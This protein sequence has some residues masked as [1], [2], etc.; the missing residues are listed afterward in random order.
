[1]T[2][3]LSDKLKPYS[4]KTADDFEQYKKVDLKRVLCKYGVLFQT[5][6]T[7]EVRRKF[8][9]D[10]REDFDI[11]AEESARFH[12][13]QE[14]EPVI[15]AEVAADY[16]IVLPPEDDPSFEEQSRRKAN[17]TRMMSRLFH[18]N[19][20][21]RFGSL[22]STNLPK[23]D[24]HKFLIE[25]RKICSRTLEILRYAF[26]TYIDEVSSWE[27]DYDPHKLFKYVDERLQGQ[28][29]TSTI[30]KVLIRLINMKAINNETTCKD[31]EK[32]INECLQLC[33]ALLKDN[34][35]TPE[36]IFWEVFRGQILRIYANADNNYNILRTELQRSHRESTV[37]TLTSVVELVNKTNVEAAHNKG[38]VSRWSGDDS[39]A[40]ARANKVGQKRPNDKPSPNNN[41]QARIGY[42]DRVAPTG[43]VAPTN[44][45]APDWT[46]KSTCDHTRHKKWQ[47]H[48][49][50]E[51]FHYQ[52]E[53]ENKRKKAKGVR[54]DED[55]LS[56][57]CGEVAR[58]SKSQAMSGNLNIDPTSGKLVLQPSDH[59]APVIELPRLPADLEASL[60]RLV[61]NRV[62]DAEKSNIFKANWDTG[63]SITASKLLPLFSNLK[64]GNGRTITMADDSIAQ[65]NGVGDLHLD[66]GPFKRTLGGSYFI[67]QWGDTLISVS[68]LLG[69]TKSR[70]IFTADGTYFDDCE[71]KLRYHVGS[72]I[73][74]VYYPLKYSPVVGAVTDLE[75][76]G[77]FGAPAKVAKRTTCVDTASD[78]N[79]VNMEDV[80]SLTRPQKK[81][82]IDSSPNSTATDPRTLTVHRR[83]GHLSHQVVRDTICHG[84]VVCGDRVVKR[85]ISA[86]KSGMSLDNHGLCLTCDVVKIRKKKIGSSTTVPRRILQIVHTDKV[87][88]T[89]IGRN[90]ETHWSPVVDGFSRFKGIVYTKKSNS[91]SEEVYNYIRQL[92][93]EKE[94]NVIELR[95]DGGSEFSNDFKD[96]LRNRESPIKFTN[97]PPYQK[98]MNGTAEA[99]VRTI[100]NV[101]ECLHLQ[102]TL[103]DRFYPDCLNTATDILNVTL[104]SSI[105]KTPYEAFHGKKPNIDRLRAFGCL[106]V[107]YQTED[108][109]YR[110]T[111]SYK[112]NHGS[113]GIFLGYK[114]ESI[115]KI[116]DL[117]RQ[118]M[119]EKVHVKFHEDRFPGLRYSVEELIKSVDLIPGSRSP[120]S[121]D[122]IREIWNNTDAE[123]SR[124]QEVPR[125][126]NRAE[127]NLP[128]DSPAPEAR[129]NLRQRTRQDVGSGPTAPA[130]IDPVG[131]GD[132]TPMAVD[133]DSTTHSAADA[134]PPAV[135]SAPAP[136]VHDKVDDEATFYVELTDES[137][138][139][140]LGTAESQGGNV[141]NKGPVEREQHESEIQLE[142]IQPE[143]PDHTETERPTDD[144]SVEI[145]L[146]QNQPEA[147]DHTETERPTDAD[148]AEP[149]SDPDSASYDEESDFSEYD[150]EQ[151]TQSAASARDAN[152]FTKKFKKLIPRHLNTFA[153]KTKF[154]NSTVEESM[155]KIKRTDN[156]LYEI[157]FDAKSTNEKC[158]RAMLRALE[159]ATRENAKK[160]RRRGKV[161]IDLSKVTVDTTV[162]ADSKIRVADLP[163][164]PITLAEALDGPLADKWTAAT[165][166]EIKSMIEREVWVTTPLPE[167]RR[168]LKS[169]WVFTYKQDEDGNF[170]KVKARLV[171]AGYSQ[172]EGV[173]YKETFSAVVKIQTVRILLSLSEL[174]GLDIEQ[175][176]VSTAFLYGVLDEPNYMEMPEGYQQYDKDGKPLVCKLIRSIYGLHQSSRVWGETLTQYL[177]SEGF[178]RMVTDS[179]V[180]RKYDESA[181]KYI[182]VLVYV[183]D[184]LLLCND[185]GT[186]ARIKQRFSSKFE[187]TDL[188]PAKYVLGINVQRFSRGLYFG[189]PNYTRE[190]LE[191]A[192][193]WEHQSSGMPVES[194]PSPMSVG[195]EHD[196][197][198]T[199]LTKEEK[200]NFMSTIMKVAY[201]AQQSR[202]D[203][204]LAVNRLSQYQ[205][206]ANKSDQKALERILRYLR[207]TWDY[208]LFFK[209]PKTGILAITNDPE[210]FGT[211]PADQQ[212]VGFSDA[213][214]AEDKG[215]KSRSGYVFMIG[216]AA[217]SW[218]CKK[219]G[220]VAL[221]STES[222]YYALSETVKEGVWMRRMLRELGI[223]FSNP[224]TINEDNQS[225]IAIALNPVHH[226]RTKH[227]DVRV[228]FLREHVKSKDI[229]IVYC[230][231]E[232]MIADILTKPLPPK[233]HAK[234]TGMMGLLSLADLKRETGVKAS[235]CVIRLD[236]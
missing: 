32:V 232:E 212:P 108:E 124:L 101:A 175:M 172:I 208:G 48:Y 58:V 186:I 27:I 145:Q 2:L 89:T 57:Y 56:D 210:F 207:G 4:G 220:P 111:G 65:V 11:S 23:F 104:H 41:K 54:D 126:I 103:P 19:A 61:A 21:A 88:L 206:V 90:G 169:K 71:S 197:N 152:E 187:M 189:Q 228:H 168:A 235:R 84:H 47:S 97:S 59:T 22:V 93:V 64:P 6:P 118:R 37:K 20:S 16:I 195:W 114:G 236:I 62:T 153:K 106:V 132:T 165:Q 137:F 234:L 230:P 100:A 14:V 219:Q 85:G 44:V 28:S 82:R 125:E 117:K 123:T 229:D 95:S 192:E 78:D 176:D 138:A 17:A 128:S 10:M 217:V 215:R 43:W 203:I 76:N 166:S 72:Q 178:K 55:S 112:G 33:N 68:R 34:D 129:Y 31:A 161:N 224:T 116:W 18:E 87:P 52:R 144:N 149:V 81:Q 156:G 163:P 86:N 5:M 200:S 42:N 155:D 227:I 146:E 182:F 74:H 150:G 121:A 134:R 40:K 69:G 39:S 67:K 160:S 130:P 135:E 154:T 102:S 30:T 9:N 13:T 113:L 233:Q 199:P 139:P 191:D 162:H 66:L 91:T 185:K 148:S 120:I 188:G 131:A 167:G 94:M 174:F 25:F 77:E 136:T 45:G 190:L 221:S 70:M 226:Q 38:W 12:G 193:F 184:L 83:F 50:T 119:V 127:P 122:E 105:G 140:S 51:C 29:G 216:G 8:I 183:D 142:L 218:Y 179:C 7:Q 213:S 75:L 99:S 223:D 211:I 115:Y 79:D 96:F 1:M 49:R 60:S 141:G 214:F 35:L 24:H 204:L 53:D 92:E 181:K 173:D 157:L 231:T 198:A 147:P 209:K 98:E 3:N 171:A 177:I 107:F 143:A 170:K 201:L 133:T 36:K 202:P 158:C 196:E 73:N 80:V 164:E 180:Y 63:A 151:T 222:E 225:T 109:L 26:P 110:Q 205:N 46:G 159:L 15:P 194:K